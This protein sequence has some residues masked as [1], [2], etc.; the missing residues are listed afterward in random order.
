[1][2]LSSRKTTQACRRRAPSILGHSRPASGR[3]RPGRAQRLCGA[4]VANP[5]QPAGEDP[6]HLH[7]MVAHPVSR[8]ITSATRSSVHRLL[9]NPWAPAPLA[10]RAQPGRAVWAAACGAGRSGRERATPDLDPASARRDTSAIPAVRAL[11]GD[12]ERTRPP[13]QTRLGEQVGSSQPTALQG[14]L[15]GAKSRLSGQRATSRTHAP[16]LPP[17]PSPVTPEGR[18]GTRSGQ[19]VVTTLREAKFL[20]ARM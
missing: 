13:P 8:Q 12:T 18:N 5:A 20:P 16:S 7:R 17:T 9:A 4:G 14:S 1:M 10:R 3:P 15:L 11:A 19:G 2:P 6:P